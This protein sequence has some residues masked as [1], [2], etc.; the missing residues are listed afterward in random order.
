MG[1]DW[2][3]WFFCFGAIY[4]AIEIIGELVAVLAMLRSRK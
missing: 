4:L 3:Y 1:I 2:Q